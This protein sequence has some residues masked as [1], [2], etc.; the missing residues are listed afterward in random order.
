M[1]KPKDLLLS[2]LLL[3][4]SGCGAEHV[5]LNR[6]P[7]SVTVQGLSAAVAYGD[8][9][10]VISC[11]S[12][13]SFANGVQDASGV[14]QSCIDSA[15]EGAILGLPAGRYRIAKGIDLSRRLLLATENLDRAA[16]RCAADGDSR[17][18]ELFADPSLYVV[19]GLVRMTAAGAGI[20]HLII[21]GNRIERGGTEAQ[22]ACQSSNTSYGFNMRLM[23][24]DCSFTNSVSKLALCGTGLEVAG[25]QPRLLIER[26]TF[27][28]NGRH[29]V[30]MLWADGL[31]VHESEESVISENDLVDNTDV[32]LIFGGCQNCRIQRNR[33]TH[34][35][36]YASSSFAAF[37]LQSWP[38]GTS[39][40]YTGSDV[41]GNEVDCGPRRRCGFGLFLGGDPWYSAKVYGGSV[42][43]NRVRN[44]QQ[45]V[46]VDRTTGSV[47]FYD[48]FSENSGGGTRASCGFR[49][50]SDYSISPESVLDR[51]KDSVPTEAYVRGNWDGCIPNFEE[52][53]APAPVPES[54]TFAGQVRRA[55]GE[56][57]LRE[58]DPSGLETWTRFLQ[59]GGSY[60]SLVAQLSRSGEG[61]HVL[62]RQ[63]YREVLGREADPS[64]LAA[65]VSYL[66]RGATLNQLYSLLAQSPEGKLRNADPFLAAIRGFYHTVL[67]REPEAEGLAF[68]LRDARNGVSLN[69][70]FMSFAESPEALARNF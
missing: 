43:G 5:A 30:R 58:V 14:L 50:T 60:G 49:A 34:S 17:C 15:P 12:A 53:V 62:V 47:E 31:T 61:R 38:G 40:N 19:G 65:H 25:L 67:G 69:A 48:N 26:N 16:P 13:R 64:G 35:E 32:D 1:R 46:I 39:G 63:A 55:Y 57:L 6:P 29:E 44:A 23:C 27:A 56:I 28:Y 54:S 66:E 18:A 24:A 42:H 8:D 36:D 11:D 59:Q 20:D 3:S 68:H 7:K 22:K 10:R 45:G 41:S 2:I 4:L 9:A 33:I 51:S 21:N 70:I 52:Y 37:H